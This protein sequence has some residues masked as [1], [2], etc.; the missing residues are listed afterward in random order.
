MLGNARLAHAEE[1]DQLADR[2]GLL[3]QQVEDAAPGR[4]GEHLECRGH[5]IQYNY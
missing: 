4:L 5:A 1:V 2:A 3:P